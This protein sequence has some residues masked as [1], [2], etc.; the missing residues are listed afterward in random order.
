MVLDCSEK[1]A[2]GSCENN[3]PCIS[4]LRGNIWWD[5]GRLNGKHESVSERQAPLSRDRA[6]RAFLLS[7]A[8]DQTANMNETLRT[9][10][11]ACVC[12]RATQHTHWHTDHLKVNV[13][14]LQS[15]QVDLS[16]GNTLTVCD[17]DVLFAVKKYNNHFRSPHLASFSSWSRKITDMRKC[18]LTSWRARHKMI[19]AAL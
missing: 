1:S 12:F 5:A 2:L 9:R 4:L 19:H 17:A 15:V 11:P 13:Q 7:G 3:A 18:D 6:A 16:S 8:D 10:G 14:F